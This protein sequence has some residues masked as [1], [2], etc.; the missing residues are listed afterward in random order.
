MAPFQLLAI[1]EPWPR[2]SGAPFLLHGTGL[3]AGHVMPTARN[4]AARMTRYD[5]VRHRSGLVLKGP[6]RLVFDHQL[7]LRRWRRDHLLDPARSLN[8]HDQPRR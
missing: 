2:E 5:G 3:T 7:R 8:D 4:V 1:V 6:A